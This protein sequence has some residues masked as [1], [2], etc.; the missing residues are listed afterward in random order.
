M[1]WN[2]DLLYR[3]FGSVVAGTAGTTVVASFA[4]G[5]TRAAVAFA[6]G[7]V[8]FTAGTLSAV[9]TG[10]GLTLYVAFRFLGQ[11]THRKAVLAGLLVDLNELYLHDVALLKAGSLHILKAVPGDLAD[12]ALSQRV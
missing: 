9:A 7:T 12:V 2:G 11:R 5:T 4:A 3:V 1:V 6:T 8:A 10:T